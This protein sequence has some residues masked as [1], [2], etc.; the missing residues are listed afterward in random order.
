M[1]EIHWYYNEDCGEIKGRS[2]RTHMKIS[3]YMKDNIGAR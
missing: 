1:S 3:E 2:R